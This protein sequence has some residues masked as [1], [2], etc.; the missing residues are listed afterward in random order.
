M[1]ADVIGPPVAWYGRDSYDETSWKASGENPVTAEPNR[2]TGP[3][4]RLQGG[5]PR[6]SLI[7]GHGAAVIQWRRSIHGQ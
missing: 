4:L 5:A 2:S 1:I 7:G 6:R 3:A